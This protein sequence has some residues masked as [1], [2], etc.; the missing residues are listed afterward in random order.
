MTLMMYTM[1]VNEDW[2]YFSITCQFVF[3]SRFE[4]LGRSEVCVAIK[5]SETRLHHFNISQQV[6]IL[7]NIAKHPLFYGGIILSL[8]VI[9]LSVYKQMNKHQ[10]CS[11][12]PFFT[13]GS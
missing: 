4:S 7:I 6:F 11:F 9:H 13:P 2:E 1:L 3:T 5:R 8:L 12:L 10:A